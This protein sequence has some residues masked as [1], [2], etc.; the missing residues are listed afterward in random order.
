MSVE[1]ISHDTIFLSFDYSQG[2]QFS[3]L[4]FFL[5]N[6]FWG[7]LLKSILIYDGKSKEQATLP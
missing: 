5:R 4:F 7:R 6:F 1:V 2:G 3:V